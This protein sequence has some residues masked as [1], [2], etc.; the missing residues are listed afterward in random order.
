MVSTS[1]IDRSAGNESSLRS[2]SLLLPCC[3]SPSIAAS[4]FASPSLSPP[5]SK[6]LPPPSRMVAESPSSKVMLNT[7]LLLPPALIFLELSADLLR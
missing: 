5:P 2:T 7:R 6:P 4:S 1:R 3:S